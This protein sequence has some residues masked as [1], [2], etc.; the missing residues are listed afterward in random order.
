MGFWTNLD[1]LENLLRPYAPVYC[2]PTVLF[3][4]CYYGLLEG[5]PIL[6]I[7][8]IIVNILLTQT[9]FVTPDWC[10]NIFDNFCHMQ[11][12][13]GKSRGTLSYVWNVYRTINVW[14]WTA[15]IC[16]LYVICF[17]GGV[18]YMLL[19]IRQRYQCHAT[20]WVNLL[21]LAVNKKVVHTINIHE[22]EY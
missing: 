15:E 20:A 11:L 7:F 12:G 17:T 21:I 10:H 22:T 18:R 14:L 9:T 8:M 5:V 2:R 13:S 6:Q 3:I 16:W 19:K 1:A 4:A